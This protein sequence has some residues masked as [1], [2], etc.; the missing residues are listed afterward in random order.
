MTAQ[1]TSTQPTKP[2]RKAK[3]P[4]LPAQG[5]VKRKALILKMEGEAHI[6]EEFAGLYYKEGMVIKAIGMEKGIFKN[7]PCTALVV[8]VPKK[9]KP[10]EFEKF[11]VMKANV[12]LTKS[13]TH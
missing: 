3:E 5:V 10:G 8:E 12:T 1:Q 9:D 6:L 7:K 2:A 11:Y 13:L 4:A